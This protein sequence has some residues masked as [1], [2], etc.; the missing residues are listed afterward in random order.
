M[1][2]TQRTPF[3]SPTICQLLLTNGGWLAGWL[4]CCL[5]GGLVGWLAGWPAGWRP[6]AAGAQQSSPQTAL[7]V[8]W[9]C[10]RRRLGS[11]EAARR[12]LNARASVPNTDFCISLRYLLIDFRNCKI[13]SEVLQILRKH[14]V[15]Y[16][17]FYT[18]E[19]GVVEAF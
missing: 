11:Q 12:K 9:G 14:S 1:T 5:A 13:A 15:S 17:V 16:G 8:F 6:P 2:G 10:P 7:G 4:A 3:L 18:C 19:S